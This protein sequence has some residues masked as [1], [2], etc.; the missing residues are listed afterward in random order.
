MR[1]YWPALIVLLN[2]P[3]TF[4]SAALAVYAIWFADY[5][6]RN[7]GPLVTHAA[8]TILLIAATQIVNA[9][10]WV[11]LRKR[12]THVRL[13]GRTA[14]VSLLIVILLFWL[15]SHF[16]YAGSVV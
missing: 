5:E 7:V 12:P 6:Q 13:L 10:L 4:A 9:T 3:Q 16:A 15:G 1:S 14:L 8:E 2:V 11:T